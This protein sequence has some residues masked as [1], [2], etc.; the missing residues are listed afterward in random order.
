MTETKDT[1]DSTKPKMKKKFVPSG[2]LIVL[3]AILISIGIIFSIQQFIRTYDKSITFSPQSNPV[4]SGPT[5]GGAFSLVD[6]NGTSISEKDFLGKYMLVFFG[7]SYCPDVCP[8]ALT[9]ISDAFEILG[10]ESNKIVPVFITVD[11]E[12]DT[13][14]QL[15]EY[16]KFFHPRLKGLTGTQE[17]IESVTKKFRVYFAKSNQNKDDA[18]DY[19]MDHSA[20]TYMMGPDGVFLGHFSHG[21]EPDL[22][23]KR[24]NERL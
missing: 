3:I 14:E 17:Q 10:E 20:V 13:P 2:I 24:I 21:L 19:L 6:E 9:N 11:P 7:Y 5:I 22:L 4:F 8:M 16:V 18:E 1:D 15:K 23:A 12:R